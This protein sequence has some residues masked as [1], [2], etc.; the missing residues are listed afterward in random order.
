MEPRETFCRMPQSIT[1]AAELHYSTLETRHPANY[2][3]G[4]CYNLCL[5]SKSTPPPDWL[6]PSQNRSSAVTKTKTDMNRKKQT[7]LALLVAE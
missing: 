3:A 5:T 1:A 6:P 2:I 4:V 7:N